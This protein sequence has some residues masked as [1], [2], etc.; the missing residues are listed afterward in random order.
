[1]DVIPV[2]AFKKRMSLEIFGTWVSKAGFFV[3]NQSDRK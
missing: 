1:M 3:T 2:N